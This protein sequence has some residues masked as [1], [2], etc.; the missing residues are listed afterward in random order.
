[1]NRATSIWSKYS[2]S[3]YL[4]LI[5][6]LTIGVVFM[7][8]P[9]RA[10]F[11][12]EFQKGK[13]WRHETLIAP[14]SFA[15]NKAPETL[16]AE[17]D[18][19]KN[20]VPPYFLM[21]PE[22][23]NQQLLILNN[24]F[25][26]A[27]NK[28]PIKNTEKEEIRKNLF[29]LISLV[30]DRG[31]IEQ[32]SDTHPQLK[33][34]QQFVIV[35]NNTASTV[36]TKEVLSI[37]QAYSAIID[38]LRRH[39]DKYGNNKF[40]KSI[41][42]NSILSA[43]LFFDEKQT[44][45]IIAQATEN[46]SR[47][48]GMIQD[49]ERIISKGDLITQHDFLVLDSLRQAIENGRGKGIKVWIIAL[50]Q[51]IFTLI[52]FTIL[53]IYFSQ[54][55]KD[56]LKGKRQMACILLLV[57]GMVFLSAIVAQ[58]RIVPLYIVPITILPIII[59]IFFD[60]RTAMFV[61]TAT[62]LLIG[63]FAPNG[64]EYILMQTI[65]SFTAIVSLQHLHKRAHLVV[66]SFL[67]LFSYTLMSITLELIQE[68]NFFSIHYEPLKWFAANALLIFIAY[69]LIWLF[70][71]MFGFVSD[72]TL[73]ELADT[74]NPLLRKL[75]EVAPGTFQ[76]TIQVA[77]I[78]EEAIRKIGGN[79]LLAR[80]GALYH[81]IGKTEAPHFFT[82]NQTSIQNPHLDIAPENSAKIIID[83]VAAG[84]KLALKHNLP[85]SIIEFIVGHHGKSKTGYFF[86]QYKSE[87]P[88][89]K[90][91]EAS[92]TYP[93][94]NPLNKEVAVVML[95][96]TIEAACRSLEDKTEES[97]RVFINKLVEQKIEEGLLADSD[98]T[99]ADIKHLKRIFLEKMINIYH[100]RI[101]Y[102]NNN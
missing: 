33:S 17:L 80:V 82:E 48:F 26:E 36:D 58:T 65:A 38:S 37:K 87:H 57:A 13:P 77:N 85:Q 51:I 23:K 61:A 42:I 95:A 101:A 46:I 39:P 19:A 20:K 45:K 44:E 30:Y 25:N 70:E 91:D 100:V 5:F 92:F 49:G 4:I 8:L 60:S 2:H 62:I 89:E 34:E 21:D 73:M 31:I 15:I 98:L 18:S 64:Y 16:K 55:R 12:Y 9:T 28:H 75:A 67:V 53:L 11:K 50:G 72:V 59:R 29:Q 47:S 6:I 99:F 54:F 93:G 68:G 52:I 78:A 76:H 88:G 43:N 40:A 74:N 102:P 63:F 96:D 27:W 3:I 86:Q 79:T 94:P 97:L 22:I 7:L 84:K 90:I 32:S 69:P 1:M 71:K 24:S 14:F 83:H 41:N 66:T 10:K 81:D 56:Y 35:Q